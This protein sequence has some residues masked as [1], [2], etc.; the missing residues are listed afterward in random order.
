VSQLNRK[1]LYVG[2]FELPDKNAAAQRVSVNGRL[3]RDLGYDVSFLGIT[4]SNRSTEKDKS[5]Y[6]ENRDNT[7]WNRK[8]PETYI[9][10]VRYSSSI[11]KIKIIIQ[12]HSSKKPVAIIAYNYPSLALFRL[13]KYCK[14]SKIAL[15]ADC[16]EW[17]LCS[18]KT[19]LGIIRSIDTFLRMRW[20]HK[21]L[22]GVIV[23]SSFLYNYYNPKTKNVFLLPPLVDK[24]DI[25]WKDPINDK[26]GGVVNLVYAGSPGAGNKDRLDLIIKYLNKVKGGSPF[27]LTI[28]GVTKKQ[29]LISFGLNSLPGEMV[30]RV[31]FKGRLSRLETIKYI[32]S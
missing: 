31:S 26:E 7:V 10:W 8:Y 21:S 30:D 22:D 19:V 5:F 25:K 11:K 6:S 15:I 28:I 32:Q 14:K 2:G 4:H 1:I 24:T 20:I 9:D 12:E 17:S 13:S 16:T 18:E 3:L 29:Y 27:Q 23:I